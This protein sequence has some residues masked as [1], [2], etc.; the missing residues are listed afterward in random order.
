MATQ[1]HLIWDDGFTRY[2]FGAG[3]PMSPVRL[4]LTARLCRDFGLFD[5]PQVEVLA[6]EVAS[7]EALA[8]VHDEAFIAAV[9]AASVDPGAA[10]PA[11]GLGTD[12]DPAFAGMH[13]ISARIA[14]GT[15]LVA[16]SVWTG[17]ASHGV[18]FTGGLHHAMPDRASGFCIYNDAAL[19]ISWLLENGAERVTYVDV[20]AHHGDGVERMFWNDPRVLT[21][22]MHET[23]TV[24]FPGTGFPRDLGGPDAEG[25]AINLALPPGTGDGAWLRGFHAVVPALIRA[26]DPQVLITQHGADSHYTDPLAH[27]SIS[28]DAQRIVAQT[29]HDLSHEVCGGRWVALGGGGYEVVGVV[30]RSWTH[31]VATAAHRDIDVEAAVPQ[32]WLDDVSER[33]GVQAPEK[34]GDGTSERG[35]I[36][37]RSWD[38][39]FDPENAADRAIMATREASF[40]LHGLDHWFD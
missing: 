26:F 21:I 1:A 16:Q 2:N 40:S 17:A 18:N 11:F 27:L 12:D 9:R 5:G 20:D 13:E 38:S 14:E 3:H 32:R 7:D 15:R 24:L 34:M 19:A 30:P 25:S 39:G 28:V 33:I 6:P 31:V 23:G 35:R 36:W 10:D 4:D 37:W 29:L 8:R 22:S